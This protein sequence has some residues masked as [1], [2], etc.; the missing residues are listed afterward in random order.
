VKKLRA[1]KAGLSVHPVADQAVDQK[2]RRAKAAFACRYHPDRVQGEGSEAQIRTKVFK[3]YWEELQRIESGREPPKNMR[4]QQGSVYPSNRL[5]LVRAKRSV[6]ALRRAAFRVL[7][8]D[9]CMIA[10]P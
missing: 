1:C 5:A 9:S 7:A 8:E 10:A 4:I 3:E 2:F 6:T